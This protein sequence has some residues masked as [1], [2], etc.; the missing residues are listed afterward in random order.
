MRHLSLLSCLALAGLLGGCLADSDG[1]SGKTALAST[2]SD[3]LGPEAM[4]SP[5]FT[6][7]D[8]FEILGKVGFYSQPQYFGLLYT[9][10]WT[11]WSQDDMK[12][13]LAKLA[14]M[15]GLLDR[16]GLHDTYLPGART[17]N[18][19]DVTCDGVASD[20]R[21]ID[22]RCNDEDDPL[23]GAAG[24]RF[25]RNV[26]LW[27]GDVNE[28]TLLEP[29]PREISRTLLRRKNFKPIP[30]LNMLAAAW[31][32]FQVH[33]WFSHGPNDPNEVIA[34]PLA[35]DDELRQKYGMTAL[36]IAVTLPDPTRTP[37]EAA[38]PVTFVNEVTH[39]W[40]GSQVYGSDQGTAD[41]LRTFA[42]GKL[43]VDANGL[44][45]AA[46]DGFDDTGFRQNWWIGLSLLHNLFTLEHNAIADALAA[47]YPSWTDQQLYD[48]ARMINA[49]LIAKIHTIE[50]TPAIL[51]NKTLNVG[52]HANWGGL[53]QFIEPPLPP[54]QWLPEPYFSM[55]EPAFP[56]L[57]G[58]L[59]GELDRKGVRFSLTEE[60]VSVYRMHPLL[61]EHI[62]VRSPRNGQLVRKLLMKKTRNADARDAVEEFGLEQ[63]MYSFGT[64]H[65]GAMVLDNFPRFMQELELPFG[66]M[67]LGTVDIVRDRE[68]GV[69]RYNLFR[70][71]I[72]LRP[73]TSFL[74]ITGDQ[75][76]ADRLSAAYGGDIS[77]L[78]L[79][80]GIYAEATRP[81]CYGF[82]ETAFQIFTLMASRRLQGDRFYTDSFNS[83]VYT[84]EGIGWIAANDMKTVLL[85]HFPDLA[86]TG[87]ADVSN[88]FMPW[89]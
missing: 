87:L 33:D 46:A 18:D 28:A 74:D 31:V 12:T 13:G 17:G 60:F 65:P 5:T 20:V 9:G 42:G 61:P 83:S 27:A 25:G 8:V 45:P 40:D 69:P 26:P 80:V 21:A 19:D 41:R 4:E 56:I 78:D 54:P 73:A 79:M 23:M 1:V 62:D 30:F 57:Y 6:Q 89:E 44:L 85:R 11:N 55:L 14:T 64:S 52:M 59:G 86:E 32:Q 39:W 68:R 82:G 35:E 47:A 24:V 36:P 63:L 66:V 34:V 81:E 10:S 49:A 48:K 72:G 71:L 16:I 38:L 29:N 58:I 76:L 37:E 50:W 67:D 75:E 51:P 15:R 70:Q 53:N 77:K 43:A 84:P 2:C 7:P 3:C 22:G 88:A